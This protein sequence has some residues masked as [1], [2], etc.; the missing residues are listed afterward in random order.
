MRKDFT[1]VGDRFMQ[2]MQTAVQKVKEF[3]LIRH[4]D[5]SVSF[6]H[7]MTKPMD[8][9]EELLLDIDHGKITIH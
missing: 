9:I 6:T 7:T 3:D 2:F 5:E 4:L 8:E 1:N